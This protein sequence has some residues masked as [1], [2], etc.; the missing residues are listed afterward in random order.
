MMASSDP[1]PEDPADSQP[2]RPMFEPLP[3]DEERALRR[4]ALKRAAVWGFG[5]GMAMLIVFVGCV[6]L[7]YFASQRSG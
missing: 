5:T 7:L 1:P 2:E 6:L 3:P 4:L